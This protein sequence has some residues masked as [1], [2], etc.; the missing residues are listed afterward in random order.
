M[1]VFIALV[2]LA[3]LLSGK[4]ISIY[5]LT[6]RYKSAYFIKSSFIL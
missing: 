4:I 3:K 5:I 2:S 6:I 1:N